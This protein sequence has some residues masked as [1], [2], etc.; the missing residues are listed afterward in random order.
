M[1]KRFAVLAA[2]ACV[3]LLGACSREYFSKG[4]YFDG[5]VI[6][7]YKQSSSRGSADYLTFRFYEKGTYQVTF[8]IT[9]GK[10]G[11]GQDKIPQNF[12]RTFDE[13]PREVLVKQYILPDFLRVT[14]T[15]EGKTEINDFS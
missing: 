6:V 15:K 1:M 2:L 4:S 3:V 14:I 8:S 12:T 9:P 13:A 7:E 5:A 11:R 10:G